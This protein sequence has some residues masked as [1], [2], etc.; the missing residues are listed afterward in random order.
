MKI[1]HLML[2]CFYIDNF[3]YQENMLPKYHKKMGFDV[4]IIASLESYDEKGREIYLPKA[5]KYINEYGIPVTRLAYRHLLFSKKLRKYKGFLH[6]LE[7]SKPDII[8]IHG[9][10]FSDISILVNYLKKNKSTIVY[11]DNH[12][13]FSNSATNWISKNFLH[14]IV[15]KH[16]AKMI[17]PYVRK[18]YGVLPARVDFLKNIYCLPEEKISLLV[19]GADD[20]SVQKYNGTYVSSTR[21]RFSISNNDF[22]IVTGGKID[23]FKKQTLLLMEAIQNLKTPNVKLIIF[24]SISKEIEGQ[25]NSLL[26][27]RIRYIGWMKPEES[28]A[29]FAASDL[30][31][32]PGR[33][34]VYWEQAAAQGIPMIV[35]YWN[36]TDHVNICNNVRFLYKDSREEIQNIIEEVCDAENYKILKTNAENAKHYFL[37][38]EIAKKSIE[39]AVLDSNGIKNATSHAE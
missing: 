35:K 27:D 33:H 21:Q 13:D 39:D 10:Q 22:L 3:S 2:A 1:L 8:F 11:A 17:N 30:V 28:Y 15:W 4:D 5:S 37:Y 6:E 25:F 19:M 38:S 12:S 20:E 9:I 18:F 16:Y 34:S 29:I 32:F 24:G 26:C 14:K 23:S 31:V 7:Q 36:G